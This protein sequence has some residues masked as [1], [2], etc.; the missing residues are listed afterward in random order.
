[1]NAPKKVMIRFE[2]AS[3]KRS[4]SLINHDF[5]IRKPNYLRDNMYHNKFENLYFN[6]SANKSKELSKKSYDEYNELY[7]K[8]HKRNLRIDKNS[9]FLTGVIITSN[10]VND[11]LE[12][13]KISKKELE[14]CFINSIPMIEDK[15]KEILGEKLKLFHY[16]IHYDEKT[17]HLH[18]AF[19]NHT[20]KG[21]A[22]FYKIKK[23][24]RLN[25]FQD[26][27]ADVFK[28]IELERGERKSKAKHLNIVQMHKEEIK[29]LQSEIKDIQ[30]FKK[31]IKSD[32]EKTKEQKKKELDELDIEIKTKRALINDLKTDIQNKKQVQV[33][34]VKDL[35]EKIEKDTQK[36]LSSSKDIIVL[37]NTTKEVL[38][39]YSKVNFIW[40][41]ENSYDFLLK[42]N[43]E[44]EK[45]VENLEEKLEDKQILDEDDLK[46]IEY[47]AIEL[48]NKINHELFRLSL[49]NLE[50]SSYTQ[51]KTLFGSKKSFDYVTYI[52]QS[53]K[54][55][56][57]LSEL[58]EKQNSFITRLINIIKKVVN[59][60]KNS[61]NK[62]SIEQ[63]TEKMQFKQDISNKTYF[64]ENLTHT[65]PTQQRR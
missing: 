16:V 33:S 29:S 8:K 43:E 15:I 54:K 6:F 5:R 50:K 52:D 65:N 36:I 26:V 25:E 53:K 64:D 24:G 49:E 41:K 59:F 18:F 19:S 57:F 42:N 63:K 46:D 30:S 3:K 2:T 27:V 37:E 60:F 34:Q 21:E 32:I 23:S 44:L 4:I 47:K 55:D 12:N 62:N 17:P 28:D 9:D 11:W 1:M 56:K 10:I 40:L 38:N 48:L 51:N 58:V 7:K 39:E 13:Q 31:S 22:A 61:S 45:K 20:S 14:E 35:E